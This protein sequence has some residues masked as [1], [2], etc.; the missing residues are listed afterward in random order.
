MEAAHTPHKASKGTST[1]A[2]DRY[3]IPL[4][5]D[6]HQVKQHNMGWP[7]FAAKYLRGRDPV[8]LSDEYWKAWPGRAKWEAGL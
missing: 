1:K 5:Y 8:A 6:C 4:S 7:S 2:A 3:C